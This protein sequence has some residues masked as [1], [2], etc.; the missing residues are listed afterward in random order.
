MTVTV[1]GTYTVGQLVTLSGFSTPQP[2]PP[3]STR[4]R[5]VGTGTFTVTNLGR[6]FAA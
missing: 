2:C 3:P 5:P 1:A 6:T 4:S